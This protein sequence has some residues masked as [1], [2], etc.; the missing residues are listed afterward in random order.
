ME[1]LPVPSLPLG[2]SNPIHYDGRFVLVQSSLQGLCNFKLPGCT[3]AHRYVSPSADDG[4]CDQTHTYR[5]VCIGMHEEAI[6]TGQSPTITTA[7]KVTGQEHHVPGISP[8]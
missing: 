1:A 4:S 5:L 6:A 7:A 2:T 3:Q 8:A